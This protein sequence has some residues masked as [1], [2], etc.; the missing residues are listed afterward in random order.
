M[1]LNGR[2]GQSGNG[3]IR[4]AASPEWPELERLGA[5]APKNLAL[6]VMLMAGSRVSAGHPLA[7]VLEPSTS[8][9]PGVPMHAESD[10]VPAFNRQ[11]LYWE[12]T[13]NCVRQHQSLAY[14]TPF[15]FITRWKS[16]PRKAKCHQS[17]RRVHMV[18]FLTS[19]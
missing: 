5:A 18:S 6:L 1:R 12:H 15:E 8:R 17:T 19:L 3:P 16:N 13:Y 11:L 4:P 7:H 2:G 9:V 10:Q 14:L